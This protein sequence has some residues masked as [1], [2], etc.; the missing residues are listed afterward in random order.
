MGQGLTNKEISASLGISSETVHAHVKHVFH[1]L[2]ARNRASA[3]AARASSRSP[4]WQAFFD[5]GLRPQLAPLHFVARA[6]TPPRRV[7]RFDTRFFL[8]LHEDWENATF[9]AAPSDELTEVHWVTFAEAQRLDLPRVTNFLL[10]ELE[11]RLARGEP[12]KRDRDVPFFHHRG[13]Q[14]IHD[15]L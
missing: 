12:L 9:D 2:G 5:K 7:R 3:A 11:G 4:A 14:W 1:K 15:R 6:I 13:K 10:G 8:T